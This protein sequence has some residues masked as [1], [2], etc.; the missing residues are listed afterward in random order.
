MDLPPDAGQE[1]RYASVAKKLAHI[2]QLQELVELVRFYVTFQ[3]KSDIIYR[4]I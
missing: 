1:A 2:S 4:P 3:H